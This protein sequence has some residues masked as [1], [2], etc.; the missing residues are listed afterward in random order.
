MQHDMNPPL[1]ASAFDADEAVPAGGCAVSLSRLV[2][3]GNVVINIACNKDESVQLN[4]TETTGGR[5][6]MQA[7]EV[8]IEAT[9]VTIIAQRIKLVG[10]VRITGDCHVDGTMHA[11]SS[12]IWTPQ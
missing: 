7:G 4:Q 10:D 12:G 8:V 3:N 9:E 11:Q 1:P 5:R 2:L 6:T